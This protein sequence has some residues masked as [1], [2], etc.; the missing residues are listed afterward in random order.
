MVNIAREY[1]L[2][3]ASMREYGRCLARGIGFSSHTASDGVSR[4]WLYDM[5]PRFPLT[6]PRYIVDRVRIHNGQVVGRRLLEVPKT[7][8]LGINW[9][10]A[11]RKILPSDA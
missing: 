9:I 7:K 8:D 6:G 4:L 3:I 5:K 2:E 1:N 11:L 10:D